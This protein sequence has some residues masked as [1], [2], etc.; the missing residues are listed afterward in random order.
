[1]KNRDVT[2][3]TPPSSAKKQSGPVTSPSLA[4]NSRLSVN[5]LRKLF[6]S[7]VGSTT[8]SQNDEKSSSSSSPAVTEKSVQKEHKVVD[9]MESVRHPKSESSFAGNPCCE[10]DHNTP[11][12]MNYHLANSSYATLG[13]SETGQ[14]EFRR[15]SRHVIFNHDYDRK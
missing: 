7:T 4:N 11:P 9:Q 13:K 8:D 12:K 15:E 5:E 1:M 3:E 14:I 6:N 10:D 2:F